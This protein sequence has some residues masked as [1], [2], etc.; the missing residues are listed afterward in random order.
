MASAGA[1]AHHCS[2]LGAAGSAVKMSRSPIMLSQ[3]CRLR[4]AGPGSRCCP[5]TSGILQLTGCTL[6]WSRMRASGS[7]ED[8]A[9]EFVP[10]DVCG[11]Y[12][13]GSRWRLKRSFSLYVGNGA[14]AAARSVITKAASR[15]CGGAAVVG[16]PQRHMTVLRLP[17]DGG[18]AAPIGRSCELHLANPAQ[19]VYIRMQ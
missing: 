2:G 6:T 18:G 4:V 9:H 13:F 8:P 5:G 12:Y 1:L 11:L 7:V 3:T 15:R 14:S 10:R 17:F 16:Y 19:T